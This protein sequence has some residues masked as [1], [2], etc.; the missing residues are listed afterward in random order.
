MSSIHKLLILIIFI[1]IL[2]NCLTFKEGFISFTS[3]N[4]VGE[5]KRA[6]IASALLYSGGDSGKKINISPI[7]YNG[8]K[9]NFVCKNNFYFTDRSSKYLSECEKNVNDALKEKKIKKENLPFYNNNF[10]NLTLNKTSGG[11]NLNEIQNYMN[12]YILGDSNSVDEKYN[13]NYYTDKDILGKKAFNDKHTITD[14]RILGSYNSSCVYHSGSEEYHD[15]NQISFLFN[16]GVRYFDFSVIKKRGGDMDNKLLVTSYPSGGSLN[17][18][19]SFL[20]V[21]SVFKKIKENTN[22]NNIVTTDFKTLSIEGESFQQGGEGALN[23]TDPLIINL[24]ICMNEYNIDELNNDDNNIFNNIFKSINNNFSDL[25][26][27]YNLSSVKKRYGKNSKKMKNFLNVPIDNFRGKI[28][29]L[30]DIYTYYIESS[31]KDIKQIDLNSII[32]K[33]TESNLSS[34]TSE[35]TYLNKYKTK[36]VNSN[37]KEKNKDNITNYKEIVIKEIGTVDNIDG[38]NFYILNPEKPNRAEAIHKKNTYESDASKYFDLGINITPIPFYLMNSDKSSKT[39]TFIANYYNSFNSNKIPSAFILK[40]DDNIGYH[41]KCEVSLFEE[42]D[43]FTD[44][45]FNQQNNIFKNS[46]KSNIITNGPVSNVGKGN[47]KEDKSK[48]KM[49]EFEI[50]YDR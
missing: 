44:K 48:K 3:S 4:K 43:T 18:G 26:V 15:L 12:C 42:Y 13:N 36:I 6:E 7:D 25:S 29:L 22:N 34:I 24:T 40:E 2:Y 1:Y 35:I 38:K 47:I 16:L 46:T 14:Y 39:N 20:T 17:D 11:M 28:I 49:F 9:N 27:F 8:N 32:D 37:L 23:N 10:S 31:D 33:F 19:N 21:E 5:K 50:K 41:P 30:I 45:N